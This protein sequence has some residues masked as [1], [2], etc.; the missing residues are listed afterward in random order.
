MVHAFAHTYGLPTVTIN[1][2]NNYGPRQMPEKLIP[3]MILAAARGEQLPV[4]GD[5]LH[6][7]DWLHVDD[8]CRA[9]RTVLRRGDVG[10]RY[11]A[12]A[13]NGLPNRFVVEQICDLVDRELGEAAGR[14]RLIQYVAD[15]PGHD[16]CYAV[17]ST[18]LRALGWRPAVE[19]AAGLRE[20]VQWYL[21]NPRWTAAAEAH[22]ASRSSSGPPS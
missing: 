15:R 16:R 11:L 21:E 14:R 17:D 2:T 4:Y 13:D 20:T 22:L 12:G 3:R 19:F 18:P 9:V 8:C 1:P 7:R 5:G 6:T 10:L